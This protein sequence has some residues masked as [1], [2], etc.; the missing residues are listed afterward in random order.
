MA[1]RGLG[2]AEH[3]AVGCPD[4]LEIAVAGRPDL[5]GRRAIG[6]DGQVD[7]GRAGSVRVEGR[8]PA[9]AAACVAHQ[10]GLATGRVRL[11]VAEYN[12]REIYLSG[13]GIGV[14]RAVPYR[15]QE[16]VLDLLQRVGGIT[17]SAAPGDVYV[18]RP[19]VAEGD[20]PEV[21]HIDLQ[22]IVVQKNERTNLRIQP[23][24]QVYVG[25]SRQ[26]KL[27]K[28]LPGWLRPVYQAVWGI[29]PHPGRSPILPP[30]PVTM[31]AGA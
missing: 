17:P 14:P 25:E 3:Y 24:D 29:A 16:T 31:P 30:T 2:V 23:F 7:L 15:G 1:T 5:T 13:A 11:R 22:A 12:S 19:H 20:R 6:P 21:F 27:E 8:T 10:L 9:D 28:C 26:G 18:V 4:V